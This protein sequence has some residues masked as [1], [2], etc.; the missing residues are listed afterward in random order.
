MK[1]AVEQ[2]FTGVTAPLSGPYDPTK[3]MIS[4]LMRQY[5]GP[6]ATDKF[7]STAPSAIVNNSEASGA[8]V[9]MMPH[10]YKWSDDIFWVFV[11]SSA[12]ASIVRNIGLYEFNKTTGSII[13]KGFVQ[14]QGTT[15][16]GNKTARGLRGF[17]YEHT[18]GTVSTSGNSITIDGSGTGFQSEGI[19]IGARIGFGTTDPTLVTTWYEVTSITN[20][21]TLTISG[22]GVNISP[23]TLYVIEEIRIGVLTTNVTAINGGLNLIKGLNYNTF[24][25][26]GTIIPEATTVDNIRASY[27]L[28]N[29][30]INGSYFA[31]TTVTIASPGVFTV[32]NHGLNVGD[33]VI[34]STT[35]AL[36]T[37]LAVNTIYYVTATNLTTNTFTV[38]GTLGAAAINTS[39]SQS[40]T[41]TVNSGSYNNGAGLGSDDFVSNSRHDLYLLNVDNATNLRVH[42][43][44]IRASLTVVGGISIS[45]FEFRTGTNVIT[46]TISQ[47]N[48]GRI[49]TLNHG[50][51]NGIKSLWFV[52]STRIYRADLSAIVPSSTTWISDSM[53]E[54]PPGGINA[55]YTQT[56]SLQQIDYSETLDRIF[57]STGAGRIGVYVGDYDP[58]SLTPFDKLVGTNTNRTRLTSTPAGASDGLFPQSTLSMW[59]IDGYMFAIPITTAFAINWLFIF[60]MAADGFYAPLTNQRIITPKLAT[61]DATKLYRVYVDHAEYSGSYGLGFQPEA[62]R[63]YFRTSGIDD[64]TGAW[65]EIGVNGDI[66][67]N[68]PGQYIQFMFE[69]DIL[70]EVCVPTKIYSVTCIYE[71]GSQDSHYLPTLTKSSVV[72]KIFAWQQ[73]TLWGGTIPDM[74]L[75]LFD[76]ST[77]LLIFSDTTDTSAYGTWEYTLD[78][79]TWLPWDDTQDNIGN[80]I[81]YTATSF[82]YSGVTVRAILTQA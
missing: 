17:V 23:S 45:A 66:S 21:T 19:A 73:V 11:V 70:G 32:N 38:T 22:T 77:N 10:V 36:P 49:F 61:S 33:S 51:L 18:T 74:E 56:N 28:K 44:N 57:V 30:I 59:T 62:Y 3:T 63:I 12:T 7:I 82:G 13:W 35:G 8:G 9:F 42:K 34:F 20:D 1:T 14:L 65:T 80:Y 54:I 47:A 53:I 15:F 31:T 79:T 6:N 43:F 50:A 46:G 48:N 24:T 55:V 29:N 40:G 25:P 2:I 78:G 71:D 16:P 69:L 37:G 5:T 4:S 68:V 41:H 72:S 58:S 52:S 81:R 64:N 75:R 27:L 26:S 60:P 39:G 76:A 67:G